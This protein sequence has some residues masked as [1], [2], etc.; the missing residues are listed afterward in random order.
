MMAGNV[1]AL[2]RPVDPDIVRFLE[3]ELANAKAG[4]TTG[5]LVL[6]QDPEG[7]AYRVVGIK[8]RF[9]IL[10][11]LSHAMHLLQTDHIE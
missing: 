9:E 10:G 8:D 1:T 4:K 3:D 7:V 6:V 5:I 11:W 2:K